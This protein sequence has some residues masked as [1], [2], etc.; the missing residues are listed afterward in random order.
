MKHYVKVGHISNQDTN[1]FHNE[2]ADLISSYQNIGLQ[3]EVQYQQGPVGFSAL[4]LGYQEKGGRQ[5]E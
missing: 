5:Y 2:L 4:V 3:V 1:R